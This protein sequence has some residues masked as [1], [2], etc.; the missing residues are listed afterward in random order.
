MRKFFLI[1]LLI[2][3]LPTLSS[4]ALILRD[5]DTSVNAIV[6][7]DITGLEWLQ[8]NKTLG[9][10][11]Q[12]AYNAY[13][14]EVNGGFSVAT[15]TQLNTLFGNYAVGVGASV[16]TYSTGKSIAPISRL[17]LGDK[18]IGESV[19]NTTFTQSGYKYYLWGFYDDGDL[20]NGV[21]TVS[22]TDTYGTVFVTSGNTTTKVVDFSQGGSTWVGMASSSH[23]KDTFIRDNMGT[24]L[25]RETVV[26]IPGA[27]FLL[28]SGLLGL[29]G[30]R[31]K[32]NN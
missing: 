25:V 6:Y 22:Y 3:F 23:S 12:A 27:I 20:A 7:D 17:V 11:Y 14:P 32:M 10:T 21:G 4:A 5:L 8:P 24:F 13:S 1:L 31:R 16:T 26:P 18:G 15:G 30:F 29:V 9:M 19:F 2:C 28:G